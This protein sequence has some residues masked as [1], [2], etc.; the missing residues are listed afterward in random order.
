M[1]DETGNDKFLSELSK[2]EMKETLSGKSIDGNYVVNFFFDEDG[3]EIGYDLNYAG[4]DSNDQGYVWVTAP[5]TYGEIEYYEKN[6]DFWA[7][8]D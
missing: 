3:I 4:G 2:E 7:F 8:F 6:D 1:R 5:F